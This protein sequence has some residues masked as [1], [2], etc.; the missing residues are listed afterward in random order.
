[1]I[2]AS[3]LIPTIHF[4]AGDVIFTEGDKA[5]AVYVI[6]EGSVEISITRENENIILT[7]LGEN[8]FFGEMAIIDNKLRS[9]KAVALTSTWC[10][11]V[12]KQ[13]F[14]HKLNEI[15]PFMRGLFHVL[16][17]NLRQMNARL[18]K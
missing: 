16:S 6:C 10:H 5:E 14:E 17:Q 9:A 15:D 11:M 7:T 13:T 1:M 8:A 18:V 12:N 4:N 2:D 3:K